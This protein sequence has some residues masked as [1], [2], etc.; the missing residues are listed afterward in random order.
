MRRDDVIERL[1]QSLPTLRARYGVRSLAL[2]GSYARG[3]SHPGS[4]V[5]VVAE[6]DQ[7]PS[8]LQLISAEQYLSDTLG[9][10]VDLVTART[11]RPEVRDSIIADLVPV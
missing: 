3:A 2:F 1:R 11:L 5:D 9:M 8:L 7:T 4:D 6:F 10:P